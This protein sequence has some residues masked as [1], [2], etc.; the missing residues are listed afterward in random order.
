MARARPGD[1]RMK[2]CLVTRGHGFGHA[3]RDLRIMNAIRSRMPDVEIAV[4][5]AGRGIEYF[6]DRGEQVTDLGFSDQDD[7]SDDAA[8]R[9]WRYLYRHHD[10]DLVLSDE[11]MSA[12]GFARRV[13][14]VPNILITDWFFAEFGRPELDALM[15]PADEVLV[16]DFADAHPTTAP[17]VPYWFGG[18]IVERFMVERASARARLKIDGDAF[19]V[20]VATGGLTERRAAARVQLQAL[21]A[22]HERASSSDQL[23]FLSE[24]PIGMKASAPVERN[25]AWVG[26]TPTPE[27]YYAAADAVIV[28]ALGFTGCELVANGIPVLAA[29]QLDP[30][31]E[32]QPAVLRRLEMLKGTALLTMSS[33]SESPSETWDKLHSLRSCRAA[34]GHRLPWGTAESFASRILSRVA[35]RN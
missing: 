8:W 31:R 16:A 33:P 5:S 28:D 6:R 15:E 10:A 2:I 12:P 19:V 32:I 3:A 1:T 9:T 7:M 4:A 30:G 18:P 29:M 14:E 20:V 27:V 22:W 11:L 24:P 26:R 17:A 13:L 35:H 23:L 34:P 21:R 25:I